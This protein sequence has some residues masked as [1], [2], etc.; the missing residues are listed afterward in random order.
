MRKSPE[1]HSL[2]GFLGAL[3][4]V[5]V[6]AP[7]LGGHVG[8]HPSVHDTVHAVMRRLRDQ[9]DLKA[10]LSIKLDTVEAHLTAHDWQVLG[11]EHISFRLNVPVVVSV[12]RDKALGQEPFWL[13][14]RG[15]RKTRLELM[16]EKNQFDV[17]E[18]AF[19]AGHVGLGVNSLSGGSEHYFVLLRPQRSGDRIEVSQLY[20]GFLEL[21]VARKGEAVYA[22]R[23]DRI[24][25]LPRQLH[26]QLLLKT[27]RARRDDARLIDVFRVTE[28]PATQ[29]PDQVVLTW[30]EDP[31]TSMTIQWR[32]STAV[33]RGVVSF[34]K[35]NPDV[36]PPTR[37]EAE[38]LLLETLETANDPVTHR[39]TAL[40]RGLLPGTT[41]AYTVG[42]GQAQPTE[43]T[44]EFTTAPDGIVPFSFIY[45]G[46]AQN[47]LEQWGELVRNAFRRQPGA[48]F[49][50]MAGDLVNRGNERDDWDSFFHHSAGVYDRRPLIPAIG[51]H[52]NQGGH[53]SLYLK[54]FTLPSNGPPNIEA[55]RA[56]VFHFSNA[57][58]IVLDSNLPPWQQR[59]WLEEQLSQTKATW[60]FVI[61]HHPAYSSA[62]RRDNR[63][64]RELWTPIFDKY[65]V[66]M[67]LQ[68]HDHA[69]LRTYPLRGNRRVGSPQEGTIYIVSVSGTKMYHQDRRDYTEFGMTNVSTYQVLDIRID[70]NRLL[71][72]AYDNDANL[73]DQLVI[74]KTPPTA[75]N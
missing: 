73:R 46:D 35:K 17:W 16:V 71:Y 45:M 68:G 50:V 24:E 28:F 72:R 20:P 36:G 14:E 18:K 1:S 21:A 52:E 69:Y 41:Y 32:T 31:R 44:G 30:S 19:Q 13:E 55:E 47:G 25:R 12:V 75:D 27:L 9:L 48:A 29:R 6:L 2:T 42:D 11:T 57:V 15:F 62:P 61:Y 10:L 22:D 51:N 58:F 59:A 34:W 3:L 65:H 49:Y 5:A 4:L 8:D 7:P 60:K 53:P 70:G 63:A 56:Y 67:A 23:G 74:E 43:V 26:G 66:D 64:L 54:L 39:H 33:K 37:V 38:T 40:L